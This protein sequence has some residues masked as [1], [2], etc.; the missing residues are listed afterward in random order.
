[1]K[2]EYL[3]FEDYLRS[4]N[5]TTRSIKSHVAN[6]SYFNDWCKQEKIA[7][8]E[9]LELNALMDYVKFMQAIPVKIGTQNI[10]LNTLSKYYEF[11]KSKDII[12]KNPIRNFRVRSDVKRVVRTPL[13]ERE[14]LELFHE[15]IKYQDAKPKRLNFPQRDEINLRM[16]LIASLVIFQGLHTGEMDKLTVQDVNLTNGTIYI[17]STSRS[18]SRVIP[19]HQQQIIPFYSYLN[20]PRKPEQKM[21]SSKIQSGFNYILDELKGINPVIINLQH[22]R[23]SVIMNW[24]RIHGKRKAQYMIG[25]RYVST[26]ESYEV[27]DVSGLNALLEK[28]H[29][30][31]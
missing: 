19:L 23:A 4:K 10:R 20:D 2:N 11:L 29:L 31:G 30:F 5:E 15:Y 14:L 1:M 16:R 13:S 3:L 17:P 22:I 28:T 25:H 21:F 6:L 24:I 7:E 9:F 12:T 8:K 27:Q 18:N 26:T